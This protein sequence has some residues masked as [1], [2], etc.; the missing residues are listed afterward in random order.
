MLRFAFSSNAFR[1]YSLKASAEAIARAGFEGIEIMCDQPHAWP[2][3]LDHGTIRHIKKVLD[4]EKLT[5][6]N[7]N[8]FMMCAVD[9]FHHPSWIEK[10]PD[11]R[12]IRV[13]YTIKCIELAGEL[14][15]KSIS[16]EPG[17][18]VKGISRRDAHALFIQGM[19]EVLPHGEKHDI[20]VLVEPE[21]DLLLETSDDY[22][23]F[24]THFSSSHLGVNL[25]AGHFYCVGEDPS[26]VIMKLENH[27]G[28]IHLEDIP[29]SREHRHVQLGHGAMDIK[30]ILN[31]LENMAYTGFVTIEL[32]PYLSDPLGAAC[33]A[34]DY[35]RKECAYE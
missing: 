31:T 4:R 27:I 15:A 25:D 30:G 13:D 12:K 19:E 26:R 7:L 5:I 18:P 9:S 23:H 34:R 1:K 29:A 3:D 8:A 2:E 32:Y 21:P 6:S 28:H 11:Y 22:L 14:G 33:R 24:A 10:D 16:T 20:M 17:G 35:L